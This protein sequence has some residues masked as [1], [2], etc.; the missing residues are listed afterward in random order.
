MKGLI[1]AL[2]IEELDFVSN[3][4][5]RSKGYWG[6]SQDFLDACKEEL[7]ISPGEFHNSKFQFRVME[8]ENR[9]I[10]YYAVCHLDSNTYELDALFVEPVFIGKGVGNQLIDHAKSL[11]T[12]RGGT[13]I[14]LQAEPNAEPFYLKAGANIV[15]KKESQSI[16]GRYL[17]LLE[18]DLGVKHVA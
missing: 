17:S 18:I 13:K 12:Q 15:G 6:Y 3:L 7:S 1:R 11:V 5:L 16:R 10:G 9:I 2:R 4:A 14:I 8:Y